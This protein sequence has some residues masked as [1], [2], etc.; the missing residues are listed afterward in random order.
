MNQH[1][2]YIL[3]Q[4]NSP[5]DVKNLTIDDLKK[6][7]TEI[8]QLVVEK[9]AAIGGHVGPNLGIVETTIAF[10]YVFDSPKDKVVWDIS[11]QSYP[12]KMLT[13]RKEAFLDPDHYR[14]VTGYSNQD[15][16]EHDYFK[17]GH[18]STSIALATGMAKARDMKDENGNIVAVIGDG[19]MSGGLALEGLNNAAKLKSNLIIIFNDNQMSIDDVN[20]GM[21]KMFAELRETNGQSSNNLF[22]A[23]GLDYRYVDNG[24]DLETM[25]SVLE[26]VKD[27]DHPI[28]VHI[29]TL[30]GEGYQP[31]IERK[32][33][34]H[35]HVPFKEKYP[36]NY[37]DVDIAEQ[38]SITYA[39]G[40]AANGARPVVFHNS[41]FLQRAYDQLEHD[42]ALNGYPVVMLVKGGHIT[43]NSNTHQGIF[44]IGMI[45]SIPNLEY[46]APTNAEEL[47]SML[48]WVLTQ[49]DKPVVIREPIT[50]VRHGEA[51][52]DYTEIN[53]R[54]ANQGEKVA[55]LGLGAFYKLGE[56]VQ[57][58][59]KEDLNIDATLINPISATTLD[60]ET[61][62]NLKKDHELVVT[63]EDASMVG[64]F[65]E[66]VDHFYANSEMKVLNFGAQKEL[67]DMV[68]VEELYDRYHLNPEQIVDDIKRV[69]D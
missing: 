68:P 59:L 33:E 31:A 35:W 24:N 62:N 47:I 6:V 18:T 56:D 57:R 12:H 13:G 40:L 42:M 45:S 26:E 22:K 27:I 43:E 1:P 15:E 38:Y 64:G 5:K 29:N 20:G 10:H 41:T 52:D 30:K 32:R 9:D 44:D 2:D 39:T 49:T 17:V 69:I 58:K 23:M 11:H 28:V 54:V 63:L 53:Y 25:I 50:E 66:K 16:S 36:D 60:V 4:I 51:D 48:R 7:A 34:F 65:G 37:D 8:R 46:L 21:Y 19:S 55:I 67:T 61:L 14:D 3:N